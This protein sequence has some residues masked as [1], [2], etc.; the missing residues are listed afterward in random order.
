M[1]KI[2]VLIIIAFL[3]TTS[4]VL[5]GV[6]K[7]SQ[8]YLQNTNHFTI[9]KPLAE[10]VAKRA[11]KKALKKETGANFDVK[12]E[13]YTTS[14]IKRGVFKSLEISTKDM[15]ID[16]IEIPYLH[17]KSLD[18]YNYIDYTKNPIVFKCDMTYAYEILL[19]DET[20]NAALKDSDYNKVLAKVNAISRPLFVIKGVRTKIIDNKLY[21]ITDYNL[22]IAIT[23]DRS[24]VA[25]SDF[26]VVHGK[27][28][29]KN[30]S[31]D[32]SYGNIGLNKVANLINYLNPLEFTLDILENGKQKTIIENINIVDNKV[33]V[34]GKIYVKGEGK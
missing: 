4:F 10:M 21:I 19:T 20:I 11:I 29:A 16:E 22:P 30:V 18:E 25:K 31:I 8:E 34:D 24:F 14:S 13:G 17:L 26:E 27:I 33:K 28:K 12:F 1:K 9:T 15:K 3:S 2:L 6:D 23:K 7:L 32:T 5:A